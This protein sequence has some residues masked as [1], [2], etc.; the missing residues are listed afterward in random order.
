MSLYHGPPLPAGS[1]RLL[2][3]LLCPDQDSHIECTLFPYHLL[4]SETTHLFEAISYVWGSRDK[5]QCIRVNGFECEVEENLHALL[6]CLRDRLIERVIWV[7]AICIN[8]KD[9]TEK[10]YQVQSMA[11]IYAKASRV[12]VWLGVATATSKQALDHIRRAGRQRAA[13]EVSTQATEQATER[14]AQA[15]EQA[16]INLLEQPWFQRIW[17]YIAGRDGKRSRVLL[18]KSARFFKRLLPLDIFLSCVA[19]R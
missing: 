8:Q 12:I 10:G 13:T 9:P 14:G 6:L 15:S 17:V 5:L 2:R 11:K 7:D 16:V 4:E 18:R 19:P 1:I 3:L